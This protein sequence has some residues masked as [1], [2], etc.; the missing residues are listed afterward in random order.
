MFKKKTELDSKEKHFCLFKISLILGTRIAVE[1]Q[2]LP[3]SFR[4][5][6]FD[7]KDFKL[8]RLIVHGVKCGHELLL[9]LLVPVKED[10][11]NV[12]R[13]VDEHLQGVLVHVP[14]CLAL[15]LLQNPGLDFDRIIQ[16]TWETM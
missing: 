1:C 2:P 13:L 5:A 14:D 6:I 8:L 15:Q 16:V 10:D 12:V 7:H 3:C 9:L 11:H 4:V